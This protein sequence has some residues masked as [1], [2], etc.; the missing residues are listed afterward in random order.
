MKPPVT[1]AGLTIDFPPEYR[2][3]LSPQ[4]IN[5]FDGELLIAIQPTDKATFDLLHAQ[6]QQ[7]Y[8]RPKTPM[9]D[10]NVP[11]AAVTFGKNSGFKYA[12]LSRDTQQPLEIKYILRTGDHYVFAQISGAGTFDASKYEPV[13]ATITAN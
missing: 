6:F 1:H 10:I 12:I 2:V 9:G 3:A 11:E 4:A 13:F 5:L 8:R 7:V